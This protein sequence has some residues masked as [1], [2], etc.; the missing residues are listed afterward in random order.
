M[1]TCKQKGVDNSRGKGKGDARLGHMKVAQR[2]YAST[3]GCLQSVRL[4]RAARIR[5]NL[6]VYKSMAGV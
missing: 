5:W 3:V 6:L 4:Q 1:L 2:D